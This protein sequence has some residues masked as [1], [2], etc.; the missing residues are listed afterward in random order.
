MVP[1]L[2]E[3][4]IWSK[5]ALMISLLIF[6]LLSG[7]WQKPGL[8]LLSLLAVAFSLLGDVFLIQDSDSSFF[9]FGLGAFLIAHICYIIAFI[10]F[11]KKTLDIPFLKRHPWSVFLASGYAGLLFTKLKEGAGHMSGAVLIYAVVLSVML[12]MALNREKRV[13]PKSFRWVMIGALFFVASDSLL[14][15]NR[16]VT[17]LEWSPIYIL[18]T[19]AIAQYLI[20]NGLIM[21]GRED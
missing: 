7:K 9:L 8:K 14:A 2:Y 18:G 21:E 12:L 6:I 4:H 13:G 20:V 16:F 1:D 19:Y 5:P 17:D 10:A 3:M 11:K 15:W